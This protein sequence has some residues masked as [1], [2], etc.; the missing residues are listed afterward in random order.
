[1]SSVTTIDNIKEDVVKI[2]SNEMKRM[3]LT[4]T[5]INNSKRID[6]QLSDMVEKIHAI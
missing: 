3:E 1:M 6:V 4:E 2:K 5:L